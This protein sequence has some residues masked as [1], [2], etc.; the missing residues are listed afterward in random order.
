M[1]GNFN[2]TT[3]TSIKSG[4]SKT[5]TS[6]ASAS[7][8]WSS[9]K[10]V[11]STSWTKVAQPTVTTGTTAGVPIGLLLSLTY[12]TGNGG[13]WTNINKPSG[14]VWINVAKPT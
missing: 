1:D 5:W 10:G 6:V 12:A 13:T 11:I 7:T 9:V 2:M 8:N 4:T 14:T 3:W